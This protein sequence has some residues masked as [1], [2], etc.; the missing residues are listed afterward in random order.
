M[1][2]EYDNLCI[3]NVIPRATTKKAIQRQILKN[4]RHTSKGNSKKC[5]SN[6]R[7]SGKTKQKILNGTHKKNGRLKP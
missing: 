5:S 1:P 6:L 3:C 7:K 2:G 4:T